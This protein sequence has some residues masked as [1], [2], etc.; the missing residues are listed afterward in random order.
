MSIAAIAA[1]AALALTG[2]STE[3]L[4]RGFL[5]RGASTGAQRVQDLWVGGWIAALAV[6]IL[7]WGLVIWCV[8]AYRRKKDETG[9]PPQLRYNV[10]IELLYTVVPLMMVGVLFYFTARDEA[11]LLDTSAKPDVTVNVVGKQ[12]SW[13]FNYVEGEVYES[14]VQATLTGKPG[15]EETLP[16]MYLPV[17]QRVEFVLTSRDVIHSFWVPAFQQKM[18]LI[19]GKVNKFQVVTDVE[20][21]YQGKCAE[22][23]GQYH[24]TMLFNVK[25]VSQQDYQAHLQTLRDKGQVGRLDNSLSRAK[26]EPADEKLLPQQWQPE[27]KN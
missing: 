8:V 24:A 25:V 5:P 4:S 9:L 21:T 22:L 17:N 26:L 2:C 27:G 12:W 11:V 13:D 20:G 18:D 1:L 7:V 19:P 23:C 10:P 14:G 16:T 3:E 6:G 15:V